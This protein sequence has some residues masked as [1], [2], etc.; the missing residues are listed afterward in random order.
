MPGRGFGGGATP[1]GGAGVPTVDD[2]CRA[3][4]LEV[5][6]PPVVERESQQWTMYA[7]PWFWRWGHPQWWSGS[8]N[9]GRGMPGRGFGGG[10]TPSGGAGVP[11]V[12]EVCRAVVLEV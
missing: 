3:V 5:G 6:P 7:G 2:V 12:D 1:S 4:V 8:P 10:A 11:T 9:S